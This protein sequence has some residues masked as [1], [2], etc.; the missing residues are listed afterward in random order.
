MLAP[1]CLTCSGEPE[2]QTR[3]RRYSNEREYRV[4]RARRLV[5][6]RLHALLADSVGT[7]PEQL[8]PLA[9]ALAAAPNPTSALDWLTRCSGGR[10][11]A[12]LARRAHHEP[13]SHALLDSY[14]Q[15]YDLHHLR[16]ML[17]RAGVLPERLEYLERLEPWLDQTLSGCPKAHARVVRPFAQWHL[18]RRA[19]ARAA[20]QGF[21]SHAARW[22]RTHVLIALEFLAWLDERGTSLADA[23]QADIDDWLHDAAQTRYLVRAFLAWTRARR[24]TSDLQV[25]TL[26]H[27]EPDTFLDEASRWQ[28]LERCLNDG[29]MPLDVRTAGGLLLLY[30][31]MISRL[32]RLTSGD[33]H[34]NQAETYLRL[35]N[36]PVLIPGKLATVVRAQQDAATRRRNSADPDRPLFPGRAPGARASN[37]VLTRRLRQHGIEPRHSRNR[38]LADWASELPAPVLADLLGI[39]ITTAARWAQRTRHDWTSF[40]AARADQGMST[41]QRRSISR[42]T[43]WSD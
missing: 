39:H 6:E 12:D 1:V 2:P 38:A 25:P 30:G 27:S 10:L 23:R 40:I 34:H 29:Q 20:R 8:T 11:L 9:T 36:V 14:P 15:T 26:P 32:T 33:I 41:N 17:V 22:A 31:Q 5:P 7:M 28:L 37:E 42:N 35:D 19:R 13:V 43:A 16:G 24:L 3:R 4:A 18:L 21:T